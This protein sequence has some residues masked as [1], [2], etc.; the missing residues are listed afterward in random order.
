MALKGTEILHVTGL[1][2]AGNLSGESQTTT[3][4]AIASL[5]T[6]NPIAPISVG[7][8]ATASV[9]NKYLMSRAAGSTLT[10]PAASGSGGTIQVYVTATTTGG[11]HKVLAASSSDFLNGIVTGE[12]GG[13]PL[14]FA[15][16]AATNHSLQMP[17]AGS[18]PSGGFIGDWFELTDV[19]ANLWTV[20]GMFQA[21]TTPTTPFAAATS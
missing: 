15:S 6:Q 10:L 17:Y 5:G 11:A 21:G 18:Q 7:T 1:D 2:G 9:G 19:A 4:G 20:R 13:T 14:G 12:N 8:S 16:A 3:T